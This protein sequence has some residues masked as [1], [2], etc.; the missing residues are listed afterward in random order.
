MTNSRTYSMKT[1]KIL[2]KLKM[3]ETASVLPW[4]IEAY[5]EAQERIIAQDERPTVCPSCGAEFTF[6]SNADLVA[7]LRERI[8]ELEQLLSEYKDAECNAVKKEGETL[9]EI[10]GL[11]AKNKE[12]LTTISRCSSCGLS[13]VDEVGDF[14]AEAQTNCSHFHNGVSQFSPYKHVWKCDK[15]G[16]I[17]DLD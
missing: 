12:Y 6:D 4:M 5:Q 16:K 11:R 8:T 9:V 14:Q 10:V 17:Q 2:L 15:C 13:F 7:K 1:D 3:A